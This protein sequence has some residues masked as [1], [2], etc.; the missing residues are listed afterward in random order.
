MS[1]DTFRG[2]TVLFPE[3]EELILAMENEGCRQ[4]RMSSSRGRPQAEETSR[5]RD[6]SSSVAGR[7]ESSVFVS[8]AYSH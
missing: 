6:I 8:D 1:V 4:T 7:T 3:P 5:R 2:M